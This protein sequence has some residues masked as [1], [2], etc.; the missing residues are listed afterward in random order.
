M[1]DLISRITL[2]EVTDIKLLN[3][4]TCQQFKAH[5]EQD[6]GESYVRNFFATRRIVINA[7]MHRQEMLQT[8]IP[9]LENLCE[10]KFKI[11]EAVQKNDT[12]NTNVRN[13]CS[14]Y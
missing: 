13:H 11:K 4:D 9:A 10:V 1:Q 12:S 8:R 2:F 6:G 7:K 3:K 5:Q 14:Q